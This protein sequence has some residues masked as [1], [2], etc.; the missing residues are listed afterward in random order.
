MSS[1]PNFNDYAKSKNK[2]MKDYIED[3]LL[4]LKAQGDER[5]T[6]EIME[7][8][9]KVPEG[10]FNGKKV[11]HL[12]DNEDV[13]K[14]IDMT[15][16]TFGNELWGELFSEGKMNVDDNLQS[17]IEE[18]RKKVHVEEPKARG[19][20]GPLVKSRASEASSS[21]EKILD[22]AKDAVYL[23]LQTDDWEFLDT[24]IEKGENSLKEAEENE[25]NIKENEGWKALNSLLLESKNIKDIQKLSTDNYN[26][27]QNNLINDF[28]EEEIND[29]V[30]EDGLNN[31][32]LLW[33]QYFSDDIQ[34]TPVNGLVA[35]FLDL[36]TKAI[37][38]VTFCLHVA[39]HHDIADAFEE[40]IQSQL[41]QKF[42]MST[43]MDFMNTHK[44]IALKYM[45]AR[46]VANDD[47]GSLFAA[48]IGVSPEVQLPSAKLVREIID[49]ISVNNLPSE[50][51]FDELLEE[52]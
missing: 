49:K 32:Q 12:R 50:I 14:L 16:T 36:R 10:T 34:E 21:F 41:S 9:E 7:L 38:P 43:M 13:Q 22:E 42:V 28:I 51:N 4:W 17:A 45:N 33:R 31:T 40:Q 29:D 18:L 24:F 35:I 44:E 26:A 6:D 46:Q 37:R 15:I 8:L 20:L 23:A 2:S 48:N 47:D 11:M 3:T 30:N 25:H 1:K 5:V 39:L 52:E 27:F 19:L